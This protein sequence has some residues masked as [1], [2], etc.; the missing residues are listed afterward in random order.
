M[1]ST[2]PIFATDRRIRLG[3]WGLGRGL[4]I[5]ELARALNFD[6]VA[7]CDFNPHFLDLFR[8]RIPEGRFTA[9]M[10][11]FL[12]WDFDAV[13]LATFCPAHAEHAIACLE[14]GKHVLSE[15]TAFHTPAEGVRLVEA[16]ERSGRV[17]QLA[18]NYPYSP[19]NRY[20][21]RK[22]AEGLF[23]ELQ[24]AEYAYVHDCLHYAYCYIDNSPVQPG[25]TVHA[26]R[27]WLPWHF[28]CTHSLG[29]VMHITGQRPRK[30]VS[31][32][33]RQKIPGHLMD[34]NHGLAGIAP[35]LIE[36]DNGG[37]VRNLM[38]GTTNDRW[39]NTLYGTRGA[40]T[41]FDD[42]LSLQLGGRGHSPSHEIEIPMTRLDR[43]A[44]SSGHGGG[45]FWVL[46][47]FAN[48][49]LH[50]VRGPFD[51]YAAADVTLPGIFA[52]RSAMEGGKAFEIPDFRQ[53]EAREQSR[54][55]TGAPPR[56]DTRRGVFGGKPQTPTTARFTRCMT[57]LLAFGDAWQAFADWS[58]V[59]PECAER[60]SILHA[61]H[62]L[63][64][65]IPEMA[66]LLREAI[67]LRDE[68]RGTDGARVLDEAIQ[69]FDLDLLLGPD[70]VTALE[71]RLAELEAQLA[72]FETIP[73]AEELPQLS[74]RRIGF[75]NLPAL[76][77][78]P[79]FTLRPFEAG[80]STH[81]CRIISQAFGRKMTEADFRREML[82]K[83]HANE[84]H[85][86]F[87]VD[88]QGIPCATAAAY[89]DNQSGYVHY[90]G[91]ADRYAGKRLGYSM[92]VAVLH[93]FRDR[94]CADAR[95]HTDDFR[96][97][98]IKTYWRLGFRPVLEDPTHVLRW[99]VLRQQL[100]LR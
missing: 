81:W 19:A 96:Q 47:H 86:L 16:V 5:V 44:H 66:A 76:E 7:G 80:D 3:V 11:E 20:L 56:Y 10:E 95:L 54:E 82:E 13:L 78:P 49:I 75:T 53:S 46:Y 70:P 79:G 48:E 2:E 73:S 21:A 43:L 27:S 9:K 18:E 42:R 37:L 72:E 77:L 36:M 62:D 91:L 92:S 25:D 58:R 17:Y 22:W 63:R 6:V 60:D 90:V 55:D 97:A 88:P 26:W 24:Y 45:D 74:M 89:G 61:G 8:R 51:V 57:D 69:R 4:H 14:A 34:A 68:T 83:L 50:G 33:S 12:S 23:G 29:P 98:A 64:P 31:L 15:V 94:G 71:T 1:S 99:R 52:Y 40:S 59:F 41:I 30:V 32:P 85:I 65:R 38:A 67:A 93:A 28:Y 35:S 84:R 39:C 87:V 100:G